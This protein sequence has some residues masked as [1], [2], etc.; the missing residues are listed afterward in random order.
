[1]EL[2]QMGEE[3]AQEQQRKKLQEREANEERITLPFLTKYEIA[4]ILG[5][6][7]TQLAQGAM[8]VVEAEGMT[9]PM[10]IAEKELAE[11][12]T[13]LVIRRYLPDQSFED[14]AISEFRR[15]EHSASEEEEDDEDDEDDDEDIDME[16]LE[17]EEEG[18]QPMDEGDDEDDFRDM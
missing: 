8:P 10:K 1:M 18:L 3:P 11:Y 17:E 5:I 12:K 2:E 13:P 7:A 6:R 15:H 16:A 9:D 4:R 14:W